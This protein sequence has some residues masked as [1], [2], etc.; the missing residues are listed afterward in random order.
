[1]YCK[2]VREILISSSENGVPQKLKKLFTSLMV[3]EIIKFTYYPNGKDIENKCREL[4]EKYPV[5]LDSAPDGYSTVLYW[6]SA[7]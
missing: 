7:F 1:M 2:S 6:W 5:L 4:I 3:N